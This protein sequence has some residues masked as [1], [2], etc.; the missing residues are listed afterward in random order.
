MKQR[1]LACGVEKDRSVKEVYPYPEEDGLI[2]D[3]IDPMMEIDCQG[4]ADWRRVTVCFEC[5]HKL[6]PDLW[7]S[8]AGW[9]SLNP[10]TAF[11]QLPKLPTT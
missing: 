3:P 2:E 1:C 6:S 5:F 10:V 11:D 9:Q 4:G 7:I 8:K